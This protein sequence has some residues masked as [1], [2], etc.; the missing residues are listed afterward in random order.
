MCPL[1]R[2][3]RTWHMLRTASISLDFESYETSAQK[4][5]FFRQ[6]NP[7]FLLRKTKAADKEKENRARVKISLPV[8][9]PDYC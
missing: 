9:T 1:E 3:L 7:K 6:T 2:V 8:Y 4:H 5:V